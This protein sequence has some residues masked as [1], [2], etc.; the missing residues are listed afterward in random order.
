MKVG[1]LILSLGGHVAI[2]LCDGDHR[3]RYTVYDAKEERVV[4]WNHSFIKLYCKIL[5]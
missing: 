1:D 4:Q 3:F 2:I 5:N